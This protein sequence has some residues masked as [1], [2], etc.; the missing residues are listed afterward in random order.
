MPKSRHRHVVAPPRTVVKLPVNSG[1]PAC[2]SRPAPPVEPC[3]FAVTLVNCTRPA[4]NANELEASTTC[5]AQR[6]TS[7]RPR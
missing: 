3:R 7:L 6:I 2:A 5:T 1:N 4:E